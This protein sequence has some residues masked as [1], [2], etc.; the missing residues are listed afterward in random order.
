MVASPSIKRIANQLVF[1]KSGSIVVKASAI[2]LVAFPVAS[3]IGIGERL[4]NFISPET[5]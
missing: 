5:T 2:S 3:G 1:A 4:G